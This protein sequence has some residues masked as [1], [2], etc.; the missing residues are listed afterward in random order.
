MFFRREKPR[1]LSF[2]ERI[3]N[4][5]NYR[6]AVASEAPGRLRIS[7]D[8]LAAMVENG[9]GD[10]PHVLKLGLDAGDEIAE[11]V[12]GG[13]QQFF[14]TPAGRRIPALAPQLQALHNFKEDLKEGLELTSLYNESL[15]TIS[16]LH[17]YDR[18]EERDSG[19]PPKPWEK[20]GP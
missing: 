11:L 7:R 18:V 16:G 10:R 6:F 19:R 5:K 4:L 1:V 8:G 9:P 14:R 17:L 15:G 12:N 2:D 13:Y 3:A 20:A